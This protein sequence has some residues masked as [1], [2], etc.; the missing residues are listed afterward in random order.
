MIST[1]EAKVID[2]KQY[3]MPSEVITLE[4]ELNEIGQN[5]SNEMQQHLLYNEDSKNNSNE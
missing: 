1:T 2:K 3:K 4:D 5:N